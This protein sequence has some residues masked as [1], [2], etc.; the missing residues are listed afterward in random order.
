MTD[1]AEFEERIKAAELRRGEILHALDSI[2]EPGLR[3]VADHHRPSMSDDPYSRDRCPGCD[4]G[5]GCYWAEWP[6]STTLLI[7][8]W[9]GV[10]T[11]D[12]HLINWTK[13]VGE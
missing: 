13:E 2:E 6:C 7:L 8:E 4:Q 10:D 9:L 11:T 5:C 1:M 3:K 12:I